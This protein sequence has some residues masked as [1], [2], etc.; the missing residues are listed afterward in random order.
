MQKI[1]RFQIGGG[2]LNKS[3][4]RLIKKTKVSARS[5]KLGYEVPEKLKMKIDRI[6]LDE[7]N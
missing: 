6:L 7:N 3:L 4:N 2:D 5:E 1:D